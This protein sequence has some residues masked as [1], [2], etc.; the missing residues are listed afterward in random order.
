MRGKSAI[1][2]CFIRVSHCDWDGWCIIY[3]TVG[4]RNVVR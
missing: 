1:T 2:Q 4:D 3:E